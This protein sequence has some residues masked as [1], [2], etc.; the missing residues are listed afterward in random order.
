MPA[1]HR[2]TT[3]RLPVFRA[4]SLLVVLILFGIWG[5]GGG[6]GGGSGGATEGGVIRGRVA[7]LEGVPAWTGDVWLEQLPSIRV[8]L[9][10]SGEFVLS[11]VPADRAYN[12][13]C[14]I[15]A[16][17]PPATLWAR[18]LQVAAGT[19]DSGQTLTAEP[20]KNGLVCSLTDESGKPVMDG[21]ASFWGMT[22]S[23]DFT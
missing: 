13:V 8:P 9:A 19:G 3:S 20:G 16:T 10:S 17:D 5:C 4:V 18:A 23:T 21:M 2:T 14:Y 6:G 22:V 1:L 15:Q 12:I 11:G 7:G